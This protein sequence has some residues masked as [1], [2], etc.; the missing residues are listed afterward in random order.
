MGMAAFFKGV[1]L[2]EVLQ[3]WK[4][5]ATRTGQGQHDG[6]TQTYAKHN[7]ESPNF[8][9]NINVSTVVDPVEKADALADL[10]PGTHVL[11]A[12]M[13]CEQHLI[14]VATT[15]GDLSWCQDVDE[16][17]NV[18]GGPYAGPATLAIGH[19][20]PGGGW[21]PAVNRLVLVRSPG[22]E[23]FV[24]TIQAVP[25]GTAVTVAIPDGVTVT[26]AWDIVNVQ[27]NLPDCAYERMDYGARTV[28]HE[29]EW[30]PAVDYSFVGN[31]AP[32]IATAHAVPVDDA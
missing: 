5:P 15:L 13:R 7:P 25:G 1:R 26:S 10:E 14:D 28:F 2:W 21:V 6:I 18:T 16:R 3:E 31:A 27:V 22:G 12:L 32:E 29:G 30:R 8:V 9:R 23:G 19:D 17:A 24:A 11:I 20:T 4:P